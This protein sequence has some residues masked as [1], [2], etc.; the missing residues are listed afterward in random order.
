MSVG[1]ALL[2]YSKRQLRGKTNG[3][4]RKKNSSPEKEVEKEVLEWC[5][6][7]GIDVNVIESKAVYSVAAGRY[8]RGQVSTGF[9]DLVGNTRDGIAVYVE[10][11]ARGRLSTVKAHQL[12]FITRKIRQGAFACVVDGSGRL[13]DLFSRWSLL[14]KQSRTEAENYLIKSLPK[15]LEELE[16]NIELPW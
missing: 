1:D 3:K 2:K 11:K 9:P 12:E 16:P 15:Q 6:K 13:G 10:L 4:P 14:I 7:L 5:Q 8:L